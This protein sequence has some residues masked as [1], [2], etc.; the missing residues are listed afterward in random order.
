MAEIATFRCSNYRCRLTF[1]VCKDFPVWHPDAPMNVRSVPASLFTNKELIARFRTE[2]YCRTCQMVV[3]D[4]AD[5]SCPRCH[6]APLSHDQTG[7]P[8]VQ[9]TEGTFAMVH[10]SVR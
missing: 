9:C 6:T 1:R 2:L 5:T 3:A 4:P 7:Q 10:L 8:C